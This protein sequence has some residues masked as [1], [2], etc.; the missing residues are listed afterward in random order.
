M[1][2]R[3][4]VEN[5]REKKARK[6]KREKRERKKE[7]ETEREKEREREEGGGRQSLTVGK[8]NVHRY[9]DNQRQ[10]Q[11]HQFLSDEERLALKDI[12]DWKCLL[13]KNI[14]Y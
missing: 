1:N 6:I 12:R 8:R 10:M 14:K 3:E 2:K 11:T 4:R 7:R 13:E 9:A 5:K